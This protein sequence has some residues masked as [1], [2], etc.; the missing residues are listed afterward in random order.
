MVVDWSGDP[1]EL[2]VFEG[3]KKFVVSGMAHSQNEREGDHTSG[4]SPARE[5]GRRAP[6][7]WVYGR[8]L[9]CG[10]PPARSGYEAMLLSP[11]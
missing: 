2:N 10:P 7:G 4:A 6:H 11:S 5:G 8:L 3:R 1:Q 9:T